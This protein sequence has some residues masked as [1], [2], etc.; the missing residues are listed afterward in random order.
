M[1]APTW[2]IRELDGA[3]ITTT[4]S[5]RELDGAGITT[6]RP[7]AFLIHQGSTTVCCGY[8]TVDPET[9]ALESVWVDEP[10]RGRGIATRLLG[11]AQ[12][13]MADR[14]GLEPASSY[15][16]LGWAWAGKRGVQGS[17]D[18]PVTAADMDARTGPMAWALACADTVTIIEQG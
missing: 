5:I 8:L 7:V 1:N 3:G 18:R 4:W 12:T 14:G 15:T 10:F 17:N 9:R 16:K 6:T 11:H 2:S 13:L